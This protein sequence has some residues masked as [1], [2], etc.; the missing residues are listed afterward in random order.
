MGMSQ[1]PREEKRPR[2]SAPRIEA[3]RVRKPW[4][5]RYHELTASIEEIFVNSRSEVDFRPPQPLR[6]KVPEKRK[7]KYCLY[8]NVSGHTTATCFD[9][10]DEIE[11]LIRRRKL[12]GFHKDADRGARNLPHRDIEGEIH[13]IAG[14]P[15]PGGHSQLSMKDYAHEV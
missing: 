6:E 10:N 3:A 12:A 9:L 2:G 7:D 5:E 15:Y 13:T 14:G 8:Y 1:Q 4:Y 11:Y